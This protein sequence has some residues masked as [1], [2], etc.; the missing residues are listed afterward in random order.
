M[1]SIVVMKWDPIPNQLEYIPTQIGNTKVNYGSQHINTHYNMVKRN[2]KIPFK[3]YCIT[4]D[5]TDSNQKDWLNPEIQVLDLWPWHRELGGC[6]HRLF[7]YS[8][9]FK[10]DYIDGKIVSMDLDMIITGDITPLLDRNEDFVYYRMKGPDGTGWR[11]NCGMYMLKTGSRVPYY[12]AFNKDPK[13][14]MQVR[15]GPG[16]DQG[17]MN[18][19]IQQ[20]GQ[21]EAHW[22]QC[23]D[24]IYDMRQ[25]II[26]KGLT[27]LPEDCR[28]LMWPGPRDPSQPQWKEKYKF[29]EKY[30]N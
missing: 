24:G 18:F 7:Q 13:K 6:F 22:T 9:E 19:C 8:Y 2:L 26:E 21:Q 14:A 20:A 12:E 3:Y 30:Y 4:D 17:W 15:V 11:M 1:L 27:E 5:W 29:I 28:I 23:E 10:E 16:T 25:D